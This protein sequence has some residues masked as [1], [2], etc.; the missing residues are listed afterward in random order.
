MRSVL[1]PIFSHFYMADLENK[2]F[3]SIKKPSIYLRYVDDILILANDIN[4]IN[5]QRLLLKYSVFNFT[6]E[7]NK[8]NKISFLDVLIDINNNIFTTSS[9]KKKNI[10]K[11]PLPSTYKVMVPSDIK[12]NY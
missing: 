12:S 5:I 11:I 7:L 8:N 6:H 9:Y 2:I 10:N 3:N 1:G 4:V